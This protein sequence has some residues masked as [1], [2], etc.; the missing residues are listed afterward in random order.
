M[1]S[2]TDNE[3]A[4]YDKDFMD[5]LRVEEIQ[6]TSN[7]VASECPKPPDGGHREATDADLDRAEEIYMGEIV[8]SGTYRHRAAL[9]AI[10]QAFRAPAP[11]IPGEAGSLEKISDIMDEG[12][13][14]LQAHEEVNSYRFDRLYSIMKE[15]R[16]QAQPKV[17]GEAEP[18]AADA[19]ALHV[20]KHAALAMFKD[21][22]N[23]DLVERQSADILKC[24]EILEKSPISRPGATPGGEG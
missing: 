18:A 15:A 7:S 11:P 10:I 8:K 6:N 23:H 21:V 13:E 20:I 5:R 12:M 19:A 9:A 2:C 22:L 1:I 17:A 24:V 14:I 3:C 4:N 16:A